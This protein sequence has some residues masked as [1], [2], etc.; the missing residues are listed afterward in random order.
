[1]HQSDVLR[2]MFSMRAIMMI[3]RRQQMMM[4]L[5]APKHL[6]GICI[7]LHHTHNIRMIIWHM[8]WK[9]VIVLVNNNNKKR[10]N[11]I[12]LFNHTQPFKM[13]SR[14]SRLSI[15]TIVC[16]KHKNKYMTASSL[17]GLTHYTYINMPPACKWMWPSQDY[18]SHQ[19]TLSSILL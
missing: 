19:S 15:G 4:F 1:M 14:K 10:K 16:V 12:Y 6:L 8:R 13:C 3:R 9:A 18:M 7:P 2:G 11:L 5:I 17:S